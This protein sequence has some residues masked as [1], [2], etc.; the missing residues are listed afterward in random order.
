MSAGFVDELDGWFGAASEI[1]QT[2]LDPQNGPL[3]R[4]ASNGDNPLIS[5]YR[6]HRDQR[7]HD[8]EVSNTASPD[9]F[10]L[11]QFAGAAAVPIGK[12]GLAGRLAQGGGYGAA[13]GLGGSGADLTKGEVKPALRDA[14]EGAVVGLAT[15]A[16]AEPVMAAGRYATALKARGK[17]G[18]VE[19]VGKAASRDFA[20]E[21]GGLGADSRGTLTKLETADKIL[22]S[23][24]ASPEMKAQA[25][26]FVDSELGRQTRLTA[27][28]NTL[29]DLPNQMGQ[30]E[31]RR[32]AMDAARAAAEPGA[33]E[34]TAMQ[35][36]GESVI[37]KE[38]L[39]RADRLVGNKALSMIGQ[40]GG[41]PITTTKNLLKSPHMQYRT[42]QVGEAIAGPMSV[43]G[44]ALQP[45][46]TQ[47]L[48]DYLRPKD[49]EDAAAWFTG[50]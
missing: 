32:G 27:W 49:D 48:Q 44:K 14:G 28:Q 31:Q 10:G 9:A 6:A 16:L 20:A 46:G 43:A 25:Q 7:R 47:S 39:P 29:D 5:A 23:P 4:R 26:A 22:A 1:G 37:Q 3:I 33:V 13:F 18:E 34:A 38:I 40:F 19:A 35:N 30:M 8:D 2:V 21:R 42:G 12:V 41:A 24:I 17:A 50:Q 11:S 15:S 36:L 45:G